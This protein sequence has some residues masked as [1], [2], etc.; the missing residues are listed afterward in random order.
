LNSFYRIG[1]CV[2]KLIFLVEKILLLL[3]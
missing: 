3:R 2:K 1:H